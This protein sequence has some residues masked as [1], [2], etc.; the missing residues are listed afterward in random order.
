MDHQDTR[1]IDIRIVVQERG[2]SRAR[3]DGRREGRREVLVV[4]EDVVRN[5]VGVEV[6]RTWEV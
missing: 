2:N 5:S 4:M 3:I 1:H 6:G